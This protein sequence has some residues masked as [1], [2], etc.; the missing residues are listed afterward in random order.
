VA[1]RREA[2]LRTNTR[3]LST[4]LRY[5]RSAE[6]VILGRPNGWLRANVSRH[7]GTTCADH[8]WSSER[9]IVSTFF[10]STRWA[11]GRGCAG[12]R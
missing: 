1:P 5:S 10:Q 8:Y 3:V 9:L 11:Y 12:D 6:L 7:A 2:G 4:E